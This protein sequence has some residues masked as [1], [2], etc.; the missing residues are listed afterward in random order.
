MNEIFSRPAQ[1]TARL[2]VQT[3]MTC[4]SPPETLFLFPVFR[5][6]LLSHSQLP[7]K[8][9]YIRRLS[10]CKRSIV[11]EQCMGENTFILCASGGRALCVV[12]DSVARWPQ[13]LLFSA[14]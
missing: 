11:V 8:T 7:K 10:K 5:Q 9:T 4:V 3:H 1:I 12:K 2:S 13:N 6:R 14:A